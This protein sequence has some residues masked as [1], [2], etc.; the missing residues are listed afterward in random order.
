MTFPTLTTPTTL[1]TLASGSSPY[2]INLPSVA[3]GDLL[4]IVLST[5]GNAAVTGNLTTFATSI[6]NT[7]FASTV[8]LSAWYRIC[9]GSEGSTVT[10][11]QAAGEDFCARVFKYAAG[12][13]H[14]TTPPQ[15]GTA[16]GTGTSQDPPSLSPTWGAEDTQWLAASFPNST[17]NTAA[18]TYP[19]NCPN[20]NLGARSRG[21]TG[22]ATLHMATANVNTAT[23]NPDAF[24]ATL[25]GSVDWI[26]GTIAIRAPGGA[27][28]RVEVSWAEL[29]VP[30]AAASGGAKPWHYY[31][32]LRRAA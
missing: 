19:A 26:A 12:S 6:F 3:A 11:T 7:T 27:S 21:A 23:F 32:Q 5:D 22:Q 8:R 17:Q 15:G 1:T 4:V 18:T 16:T 2:T 30:G 29:E 10:Y 28:M 13:W 31:Q 14:G 24:T 25:S 20:N 9:D